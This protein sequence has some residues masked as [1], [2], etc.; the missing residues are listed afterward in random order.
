MK[1]SFSWIA[2]GAGVLAAMVLVQAQD[3]PGRQGFRGGRGGGGFGIG[4]T[5]VDIDSDGTLSQSELDRAGASLSRLDKNG[6]GS[7]TSDEVRALM[8]GGRGPGGRGRGGDEGR[9]GGAP[10]VAE[11]TV[12]TLLEFDSN[13]DGKLSREE[14]PERMRGIFDRGDENKDNFLT[15][16]EIRQV[17]SAQNPAAGGE[18]GGRGFGEG[19]GRGEGRGPGGDFNAI[20]FDPVLAAV[21]ADGDGTISR[22]E[23][24]QAPA[25]VRK[26]D[27]DG[28]AAISREEAMPAGRGRGRGFGRGPNDRER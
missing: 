3:G 25:S 6:D 15:A 5:A 20:R 11:E 23:L 17:S 1:S 18:A 19:R 16:A 10:D 12:K 4:F 8:E 21:D 7:V 14:L 9:G 22:D 28:D 13:G 24:L 27:R 2:L 26:L